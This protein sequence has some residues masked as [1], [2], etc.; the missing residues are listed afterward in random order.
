MTLTLL[1]AAALAAT[2]A[3][4]LLAWSQHRDARERSAARV[5]ALAAAIDGPLEAFFPVDA[6]GRETPEA[7]LK[8]RGY[9]LH[10]PSRR[11]W[12]MAAG[13]VPALLV[14][15][16]LVVTRGPRQVAA[17]PQARQPQSLELLDMHHNRAGDMLTV[18][19]SV[20][21]RGRD[22][23]PV[24]AV[25]TGRDASGHIVASAHAPLDDAALDLDGESSFQ[26]SVAGA[27]VRRYQVRFETPLGP[28]THIDRRTA[29][30]LP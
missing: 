3:L 21:V 4:A 19:G 29:A 16:A 14:V 8:T 2:C 11:G 27:D 10:E 20:R 25:V 26:V 6:E 28:L 9:V 23:A 12:I 22:T 1:L 17:P 13:A 5:A 24:T 15:L 7:G 18:T 30:P